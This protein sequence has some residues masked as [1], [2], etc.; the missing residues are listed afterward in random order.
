MF[1]KCVGLLVVGKRRFSREHLVEEEFLRL[2]DVLVDL[3]FLYTG[4]LLR[5]R[6]KILQK[7]GHRA[8][9]ARID[10]PE[11]GND[12]FWFLVVDCNHAV[13]L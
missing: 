1:L 4:L 11:G 5:L 12:Q 13:L 7:V 2:C 6:K 10:F 8:F 3:E 9:L